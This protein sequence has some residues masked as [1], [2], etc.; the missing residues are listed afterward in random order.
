[1]QRCGAISGN[2]DSISVQVM[3]LYR[4]CIVIVSLFSICCYC[5]FLVGFVV[6]IAVLVGLIVQVFPVMTVNVFPPCCCC[7]YAIFI[8]RQCDASYA[9]SINLLFSGNLP[10]FDGPFCSIG[11]V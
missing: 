3:S 10:G 5:R 9:I 11:D 1:M 2:Y 8:T 6:V 7:C 4:H